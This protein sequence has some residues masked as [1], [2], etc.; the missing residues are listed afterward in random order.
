MLAAIPASAAAST[1]T[2]IIIK[3]EPGLS[4]AERRDIRADADVRYVESLSLP[5]TEVVAAAPGDVADAVRDLNA[6]PDVVYAEPARRRSAAAP[7]PNDFFFGDLWAFDNTGVPIDDFPSATAD[8]DMDILEAWDASTGAGQTVA[9]VDTGINR[10]HLDLTGQVIG[11]YDFVDE[12]TN[13]SDPDGHGTHVA[14]TIAAIRGNSRGVAGVAPNAKLVPL[15]ALGGTSTDAETAEAFDWAGDRGIRI[16]NASLAGMG[17]SSTE[18]A[19]MAAHPQT[20]YVVAAGNSGDDVDSGASSFPCAYDLANVICV[21]AS[22]PNDGAASFSN[23]GKTSVDVFAPGVDIVSTRGNS[24]GVSDGTSMATPHVTGEVALI[25]A[26]NPGLNAATIK[27]AV[28]SKG[29]LKPGL[30]AKSVTGRRAN[31]NISVLS[32]SSSPASAP[33]FLSDID[34]DDVADAADRCLTVPNADQ[35]DGDGDGTGDAC[36]DRDGD[37]FGDLLDNCAGAANPDQFDADQD[38]TGDACPGDRDGD[39]DLVGADNCI[40]V[41]NDDQADT[42]PAVNGIG[43]ACDDRDGDGPYDAFDNCAGVE[44]TDQ[45]DQDGDD[46]GDLCDPDRD[47][48]GDANGADNCPTVPNPDQEN[49]DGDNVGDACDDRDG[50]ALVDTFDNCADTQNLDQTDQDGDGDGDACDAD[51]DG[52]TIDNGP[53]NCD[54]VA[55]TNQSDLDRD[56]AGDVCDST[57]RGPDVDGDGKPALDDS[58]PNQYGTLANGCAPETPAP[59]P[60]ANSDGDD[61]IDASDACP[62]EY[63]I[64]NDGCPL[65]QVSSLSAKVRKRSATVKVSASRAATLTI[66]VERKKGGRWVRVTRRTVSGTGKTLRLSRLKRGSHRVR[67][68]ITSGAGAGTPVSKSF[69]VR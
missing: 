52:D 13:P 16:V 11:G 63:A 15:R 59:A 65:A 34:G 44:N 19:A 35:A 47:E 12:D 49:A 32:V 55:N 17:S 9:V 22:D 66:T 37:G 45:A 14:G 2:R 64:S 25:A 10:N 1:E 40:D 50:D 27:A 5:R 24:Y 58:C 61:R 6:D 42:D 53:D 51:L 4:A 41:A 26:R 62:L 39:G 38:G 21:G 46:L 23:Y 31:A 33:P 8:A 54:A 3:R 48:D 29:D 28:L 43:D 69:R 68:A 30:A 7:P 56:N 18:Y 57:P 36:D 20:L 60:P 67:V